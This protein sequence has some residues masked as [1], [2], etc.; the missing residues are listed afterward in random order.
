MGD[1]VVEFIVNHYP[2]SPRML[3]K[4]D[5]KVP[6]EYMN[7]WYKDY[8]CNN[9]RKFRGLPLIRKKKCSLRKFS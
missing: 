4:K 9:K 5:I 8:G 3:L 2:E 7:L 6:L 1:D